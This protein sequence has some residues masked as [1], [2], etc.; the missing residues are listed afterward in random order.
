MATDCGEKRLVEVVK[1]TEKIKAFKAP[2]A[3]SVPR[4]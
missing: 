3:S 4:G 1:V 2:T